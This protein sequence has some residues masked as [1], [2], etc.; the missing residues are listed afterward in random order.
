MEPN[1]P[2]GNLF[3]DWLLSQNIVA[4]NYLHHHEIIKALFGWSVTR[5]RDGMRVLD[6]GC[7]DAYVA[8]K[9]FKQFENIQYYGIDFSSHALNVARANFQ[10]INWSVELL[11]GNITKMIQQLH[12]PFDLVIAGYSLHYLTEEQQAN[13]L[14]QIR[15]VLSPNG[16][17]MVY[18]L[19]PRK[20][21]RIKSYLDRFLA[22][23]VSQWS[24]LEPEQVDS[25]TKHI[26][27]SAHPMDQ[28][29]W[30]MNA[31]SSSLGKAELIYRDEAEHIGLL[32]IGR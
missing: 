32:K 22:D 27:Q 8:K 4:R 5:G 17:L 28:T 25:L 1:T 13:A 21:E 3:E 16:T 15:L 9:A 29:R 23:A 6:L 30:H 2:L 20:N 18:D 19:I 26:Q 11:E 14:D 31:M 10:S 12:G 7:G 24:L